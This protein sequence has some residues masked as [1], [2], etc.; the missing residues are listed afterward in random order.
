MV[1]IKTLRRYSPIF[2]YR[3]SILSY[4]YFDY[5]SF[6]VS[7]QTKASV[8]MMVLQEKWNVYLK[9]H[10]VICFFAIV[11][12]L[13]SLLLIVF[14]PNKELLIYGAVCFTFFF[15]LFFAS[16]IIAMISPNRYEVSMAEGRLRI[17]KN[18][19][20]IVNTSG[21]QITFLCLMRHSGMLGDA[22]VKLRIN[23]L[24]ENG[25]TRRYTLR[26]VN[27]PTEECEELAKQLTL[28]A[29]SNVDKKQTDGENW[30]VHLCFS[31]VC[32][33]VT[34]AICIFSDEVDGRIIIA[35][36][37]S[38]LGFV[39]SLVKCLTQKR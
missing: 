3:K 12:C 15:L 18:G 34:G 30:I 4:N 9:K 24:D 16:T 8:T 14:A 2:S 37:L 17:L 7:L 38:L 10:P 5:C 11:L 20:E 35:L 19:Q 33:A 27:I 26:L 29:A 25:K 1:I 21:Q 13:L 39:Y 22:P 28:F 31:L 6:F 36:V 23:Y 32:I